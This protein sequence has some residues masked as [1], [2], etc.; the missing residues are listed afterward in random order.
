MKQK[1]IKKKKK[2]I[3]TVLELKWWKEKWWEDVIWDVPFGRSREERVDRWKFV[4]RERERWGKTKANK[5]LVDR[6]VIVSGVWNYGVIFLLI[7]FKKCL[8][9]SNLS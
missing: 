2:I 5:A 8:E 7:C 3:F 9:G 4:I 6:W 1:W